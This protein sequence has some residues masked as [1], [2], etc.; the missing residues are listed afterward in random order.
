[1]SAKRPPNST[2]VTPK[3]IEIAYYDSIGVDGEPQ[4]RRYLCN[5]DR[6]VNVTTAL[7]VLDKSDALIPWALNL[8]EQGL[9]WR[10]VRNDAGRRGTSTHD[11]VI[12]ALMRERVSLGDL[13]DEDRPYGQ[14]GYRWLR[15]REPKVIEAELLV[16]APSHQLA[17]RLDLLCEI[18]G[19]LVLADLKTVTK[20]SRTKKGEL[21]PPYAENL[22]QLDLYSQCIEESGYPT[23]D[24]G[25]IV[26]LG[27]D[28][29]YD[30]TWVDPLPDRGL[31][32]L[33]AYRCRSAAQTALRD[34]RKREVVPA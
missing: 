1:M 27:P 5:G 22:L 12:R 11:V 16:A 21:Y 2:T 29:E 8:H 28:G 20:W 10:E 4:Q 31:G 30:E 19:A 18:D 25:L 34:A 17:G 3:G 13:S 23:P 7:G 6:Y 26:R 24:R 15:A 9:D 32:V 14:A 33:R